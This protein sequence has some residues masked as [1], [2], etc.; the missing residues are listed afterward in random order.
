[1]VENTR[2]VDERGK[3]LPKIEEGLVDIVRL[4]LTWVKSTQWYTTCPGWHP[5]RWALLLQSHFSRC[6]SIIGPDT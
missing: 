4:F 6:S 2:F 3:M 1:M 5:G